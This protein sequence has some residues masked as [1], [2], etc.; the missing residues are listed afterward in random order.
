MI[1]GEAH[2]QNVGV[3]EGLIN[4]EAEPFSWTPL[5][6]LKVAALFLLAGFA[7]IGGGWLVWQ[8]VREGKPWWWAVAGSVVLV[9][10]GFV[11]TLQPLSDFGRLYGVYGGIFIAL[12]FLWGYVFDGMRRSSCLPPPRVHAVPAPRTPCPCRHETR[13]RRYRGQHRRGSGRLHHAL[14][15]PR[16]GRQ[17]GRRVLAAS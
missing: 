9:S 4:S 14:L 12:S 15:A 1:P 8:A 11:P 16:R 6:V 2:V 13:P 3:R 17:F 5:V 7:E 10:Y